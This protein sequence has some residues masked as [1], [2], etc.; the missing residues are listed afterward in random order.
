MDKGVLMEFQNI[1]HFGNTETTGNIEEDAYNPY[2][3]VNTEITLNN[4]QSIL[5]DYGL[6]TTVHNFEY[7]KLAF[8]HKSYTYKYNENLDMNNVTKPNNCVDL[9]TRS[10]ERLEFLGDGILEAVTKFYLY[11]R[12]PEENEGF[13]TEKKIAIVKNESIGKLAY[14]LK[15][16]KWLLLNNNAEE[17]KNRSN[18]KKLGCLFEAFL[19]AI[20]LDMN[21]IKIEDEGRWFENIFTSGPGFQLCQL[22][23]ENV[24]ERHINWNDLLYNDDNYKNKLQIIIQ[25]EF[26]V[27]P[28]YLEIDKD[29]DGFYM[30]VYLCIGKN[31]HHCHQN[32]AITLADCLNRINT[33]ENTYKNTMNSHSDIIMIIKQYLHNEGGIF[34]FLG[35]GKHKIKRKAEKM[36]CE[37]AIDSLRFTHE[38]DVFE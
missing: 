29:L 15:L 18:Y 21:E 11:K 3:L 5:R 19:G 2:N 6:P 23:L 32:E 27:T 17:K 34:L 10:N 12:F 7:Y 8:V 1:G 36:A 38:S 30:G 20:F 22:F 24:F 35:A 13:M 25:K 4:V 28:D 14:D 31:I 33:H 37:V 16:N 26:K 9:R